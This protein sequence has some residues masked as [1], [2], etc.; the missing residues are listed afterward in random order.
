MRSC[1]CCVESSAEWVGHFE[2]SRLGRRG[3]HPERFDSFSE[4]ER[5]REGGRGGGGENSLAEMVVSRVD[6]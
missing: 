5:E 2:I 1:V 6:G 3:T 4:R